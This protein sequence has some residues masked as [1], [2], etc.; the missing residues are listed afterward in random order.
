MSTVEAPELLDGRY[1][2][3]RALGSGAF[4]TTWLAVRVEDGLEVAIK[5]IHV[6]GDAKSRQLIARE[7][8]V[9]RQLRHRDIPRYIEDFRVGSGKSQSHCL[10]QQY[11]AGPTLAMVIA[12]RK[13]TTDEAIG[14][15]EGLLPVLEYL[16]GLSP[17]V[18]HRD[19]KPGNVIVRPE[20]G[21]SLVDFGSVRDVCNGS[22]GGSTI[23]GTFGY[24]APE[25]FQGDA[26]PATDLYALGMI[27]LA[28]I[29]RK[30]PASLVDYERRVNWRDHADV[31]P[32]VDA[33]LDA[34]TAADPRHRPPSIRAVRSLMGL[35][36]T[37]YAD[38]PKRG[39]QPKFFWPPVATAGPIAPQ[40]SR[41]LP[42]TKVAAFAILASLALAVA[43]GIAIGRIGTASPAPDG[44]AAAEPGGQPAVPLE[45]WQLATGLLIDAAQPVQTC[46]AG[47][48]SIDA[49][50]GSLSIIGNRVT[51]LPT[52]DEYGNQQIARCLA[53]RV[54]GFT[55]GGITV[56]EPILV[57][58][59]IHH[60]PAG[61]ELVPNQLISPED[62]RTA[63]LILNWPEPGRLVAGVAQ[64][65]F[66]VVDASGRWH[67]HH[68]PV[69]WYATATAGGDTDPTGFFVREGATCRY[70]WTSEGWKGGCTP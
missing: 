8:S 68:A 9:L 23:T 58:W 11:V 59:T 35:R 48:T 45:P 31:A 16:H 15:L 70:D 66:V 47:Y 7:A 62:A 19:L 44:A 10:V 34:L 22:L 54:Q 25:Q 38:P 39:E 14:V 24:M 28:M 4:A 43:G 52:P 33:L 64:D 3:V 13:P 26:T 42:V 65:R 55:P 1:R 18:I 17:P 63:T 12:E 46:F 60:I 30:D 6:R 27:A 69:G 37:E 21:Y 41:G 50:P 20:G 36:G 49:I 5:E 57:P 40:A 29:T 32:E 53:T 67:F 56:P 51:F 2:L 61:S